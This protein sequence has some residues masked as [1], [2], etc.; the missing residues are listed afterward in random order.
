ML[1]MCVRHRMC[2]GPNHHASFSPGSP[3]TGCQFRY[4]GLRAGEV[5]QPWCRLQ[6]QP[7]FRCCG[8]RPSGTYLRSEEW[9]VPKSIERIEIPHAI[10]VRENLNRIYIIDGG[11]G[12][13]KVY[14][15][16]TYSLMSLYL[17]FFQQL[18]LRHKHKCIKVDM[19]RE[20]SDP[21]T[22][23]SKVFTGNLQ[24]CVVR[25]L[26]GLCLLTAATGGVL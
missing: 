17:R 6:G 21:Y 2:I 3:P 12:A 23:L 15:G 16:T 24:Y 10:F 11:Q 1:F 4:A 14:D 20:A 19:V 13:L 8:E 26:L 18:L 9:Q 22:C 5:L 25:R 7:L